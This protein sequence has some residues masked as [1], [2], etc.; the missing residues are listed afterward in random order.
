MASNKVAKKHSSKV[1]LKLTEM[2]KEELVKLAGETRQQ[3]NK[4]KLERNVKK[5]RNVREV[6]NMRKKLARILTVIAVK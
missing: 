6:F 5:T 3:I 2:T 4:I 1:A